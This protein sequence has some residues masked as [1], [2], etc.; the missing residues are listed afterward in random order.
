[1]PNIILSKGNYAVTIHA[2]QIEDG[3]GNKLFQITP[4][5]PIQSQEAGSSPTIIVDLLRLTR[6]FRI[7]GYLTSTLE[8]YYLIK[9]I[10]GGGING[11]AVQMIYP[12]GGDATSFV[13]FIENYVLTQKASDFGNGWLSG[14]N[15]YKGMVVEYIGNF[16]YCLQ[17]ALGRTTIPPNDSSYWALHQNMD[18][19]AKHDVNITLVKGTTYGG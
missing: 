4:A 3:F 10:E 9:I 19:F 12:D 17:D 5:T 11:G 13:V 8:K 15:Y 6:T 1:M 16:Y 2:N 18:N 14:G 7:L